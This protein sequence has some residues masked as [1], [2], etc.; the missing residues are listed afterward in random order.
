[1]DKGSHCFTQLGPSNLLEEYMSQFLDTKVASQRYHME[2]FDKKL[3]ETTAF[4]DHNLVYTI[5]IVSCNKRYPCMVCYKKLWITGPLYIQEI[6]H[7]T[8]ASINLYI[9]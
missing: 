3:L 2:L 8:I 6:S 9:P 4:E 1:M 7:L 5:K